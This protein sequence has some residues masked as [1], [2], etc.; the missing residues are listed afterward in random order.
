MKAIVTLSVVAFALAVTAPAIA[1]DQV[2]APVPVTKADCDKAK[3]KW[4]D[5]SKKCVLPK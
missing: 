4:D 3:G 1:A 5:A 2:A